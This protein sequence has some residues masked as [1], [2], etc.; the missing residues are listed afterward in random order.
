M[1]V[2]HHKLFFARSG[3]AAQ[4]RADLVLQSKVRWIA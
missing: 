4:S 2:G 3:I 1:A